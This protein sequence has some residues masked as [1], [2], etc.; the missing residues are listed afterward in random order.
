MSYPHLTT[1]NERNVFYAN[2]GKMIIR[3][4]LGIVTV[5]AILLA[6]PTNG[7]WTRVLMVESQFDRGTT[8]SLD[9]DQREYWITAKHILNGTQHPP[10][11]SVKSKSV[12]LKILNP[13]L[14]GEQWLT[15]D[16]SILDP[17]EDIDIIILA[18]T[19]LLL[20]NPLSSVTPS[21]AGVVL[22]ANCEFLG[23]PYGG[24]W[25]ATF[26]DAT[27]A[28]MPFVKH[29][30]VSALASQGDKRFWILDGINNAGFSGGPVA[31]LTGPQ[32]QIFA[33]VS[34]YQT[35]PT[36]V[37]TSP[38]QK[39]LPPKPQPAPSKGSQAKKGEDRVK[40][41]VNLNSGFIIAFDIQSAID[42]IHKNPIGP[43]REGK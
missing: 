30:F 31:Y 24:G 19:H 5:Q 21:S 37:I 13:G 7:L 1:E 14:Q 32:Q 38:L 18:P 36:E 15:A 43:L 27:S 33:V 16:F 12:R 22:G 39:P 17:G 2:E 29:C 26:S 35:E 8:F 20:T 42:A 9:V 28:W 4:F 25:R 3:L 11:G 23:F 34:G 6:Q 41:T 40:Q 10:F